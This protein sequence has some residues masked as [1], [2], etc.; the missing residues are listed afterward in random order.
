MV[1]DITY[2]QNSQTAIIHLMDKYFD[3]ICLFTICCAILL[4]PADLA[5]SK[6]AIVGFLAAIIATCA[7]LSLSKWP[8][9]FIL[10]VYTIGACFVSA[11]ISFLPVVVYS[12]M[13]ERDWPTRLLWIMPLTVGLITHVPNAF[14]LQSFLL[15]V[16]ACILGIKDA[17]SD[18]EWLGLQHA[19]DNVRE[20]LLALA[21]DERELKDAEMND[22]SS[23]QKDVL[24]SEGKHT[25]ELFEGLTQREIAVVQLIAKGMDNREISQE[26]YLSEGTVRNH[27]SSILS[28]KGL[29][30]RTQIAI[31]YY[32]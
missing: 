1:Q 13:H 32:Q 15:C 8:R 12:M 4:V 31:K 5:N 14:L 25:E 16:V 20:K 21:D 3:E 11:L 23:K 28:K 26:L 17:R 18:S 10:I 9:T 7:A 24:A 29:S 27:I 30:N 2:P 6:F 22:S 19:Y